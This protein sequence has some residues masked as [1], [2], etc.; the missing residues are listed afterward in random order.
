MRHQVGIHVRA[1]HPMRPGKWVAT[2]Q[3]CGWSSREYAQ[4]ATA[5]KHAIEHQGGTLHVWERVFARNRV[6]PETVEMFPG[7]K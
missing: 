5:Q 1:S 2:C 3:T 4:G 7:V 6:M